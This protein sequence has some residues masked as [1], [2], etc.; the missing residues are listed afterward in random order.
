[1][2]IKVNLERDKYGF[3][4]HII[5]H[6]YYILCQQIENLIE[7][8]GDNYVYCTFQLINVIFFQNTAS[9]NIRLQCSNLIYLKCNIHSLTEKF[10]LS[11]YLNKETGLEILKNLIAK[12]LYKNTAQKQYQ[13]KNLNLN[14]FTQINFQFQSGSIYI[15]I[16]KSKFIMYP[17]ENASIF[18]IKIWFFKY[19][20]YIDDVIFEV[21]IGIEL[22][23]ELFVHVIVI[24]HCEIQ[25]YLYEREQEF[26]ILE[27]RACLS[28]N[29]NEIVTN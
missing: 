2:F 11:D 22:Y 10:I 4:C 8:I 19:D 5:Q 20:S 21:V 6:D 27:L 13:E 9:L 24:Q 1:M 15:L 12:N 23:L 29:S 17:Q 18:Y 16:S 3:L 25:L 7:I 14:C 28:V 26:Y